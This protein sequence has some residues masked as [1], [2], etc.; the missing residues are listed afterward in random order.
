MRSA[1]VAANRQIDPKMS[2]KKKQ[3]VS[4]SRFCLEG[5]R[6]AHRVANQDLLYHVVR[7]LITGFCRN[8]HES[9]EW[10]KSQA[11]I[12]EFA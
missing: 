7:R 3:T 9:L 12:M 5:S 11:R 6:I 1:G 8:V 4:G 2:R 10:N